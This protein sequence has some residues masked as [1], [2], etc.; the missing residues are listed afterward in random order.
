[1]ETGTPKEFHELQSLLLMSTGKSKVRKVQ[2]LL[3]M[4]VGKSG[5]RSSED[6]NLGIGVRCGP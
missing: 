2:S 5:G 4:S 6:D 3:L 1:M